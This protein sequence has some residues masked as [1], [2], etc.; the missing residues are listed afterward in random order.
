MYIGIYICLKYFA[1]VGAA[2]KEEAPIRKFAGTLLSIFVMAK[3]LQ[4]SVRSP[5]SRPESEKFQPRFSLQENFSAG[6]FATCRCVKIHIDSYFGGHAP[7]HI[8]RGKVPAG[9]AAPPGERDL[10]YSVTRTTQNPTRANM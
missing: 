3:F 2:R 1:V 9:V 6:F 5:H 7:L 8:R 4:E 10:H